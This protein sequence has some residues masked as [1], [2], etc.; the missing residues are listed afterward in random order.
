MIDATISAQIL[1]IGNRSDKPDGGIAQVLY[2]YRNHVYPIFN[3]VVNFKRGNALYKTFV[4]IIGFVKTFCVLLINRRIRIVHIHTAS[5]NGFKR[6]I[7][8][9]GLAHFMRKNVVLHIHSG[10]FN[11][12]YEKN[13]EQVDKVFSKCSAIVALSNG[14]KEFYEKMGCNNVTVVNNIIEYPI[15]N[16]DR[17]P[18]GVLHYLYLGVITKTKGIYD[19]LDVIVNHKDEFRGKMLLHVG[20]NKEVSTLQHIIKDNHIEDIV[21]FEGWVNGQKKIE[22]LN[23]CDVFVL[24]SYTEGIPISILEAQSYGLF[25]IAT[26]VG[27]IPEMIDETSG[28]LFEPGNQKE[29]YRILKESNDKKDFI[30][31]RSSIRGGIKNHLPE[32]V[33]LQLES[34]YKKLLN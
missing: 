13:K 23:L 6:N 19:L 11:E 30:E 12:Y 28:R 5:G 4:T 25:T 1:T 21:T 33:S 31:K 24:P 26:N 22:L 27:G 20:G 8:F 18:T 32:E 14:I 34:L 2:S 10:R 15:I 16:D 3:H 9:V 17:Q 29:L 7:P